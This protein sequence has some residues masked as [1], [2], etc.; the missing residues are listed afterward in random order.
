MADDKTLK[1]IN[2]IYDYVLYYECAQKDW[3][4][5]KKK[6]TI[7]GDGG[8]MKYIKWDVT[9]TTVKGDSG[10]ATKFGITH[11]TWSNYVKSHPN[12]GY[13]KDVNSMNKQGWLDVVEWFWN[14]LSYAGYAANYACAIVLFQMRWGGYSDASAKKCLSALK[15]NADKKDYNYITNG[16]SLKKIADATHAFSD[17]MKAFTILRKSLL[18]YYYNISTPNKTNKKFRVG[19]FNRVAIPFSAYGLYVDVGL[20]GGRTLKLKYESTIDDWENALSQHFKNGAKGLRKIL[21]W[22]IDPETAE[23]LIAD[24]GSYDM[25]TTEGSSS[26]GSSSGSYKGCGGVYNLGDYS[27]LPD[28]EITHQQVQSREEVLNTLLGGSYTPDD[29]KKCNELITVDKKKSIKV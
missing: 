18:T 16:A 13:N 19:W 27:N 4:D 11:G 22:G 20:N 6:G 28:M 24:S 26:S 10:G 8:L 1:V 17:P 25:S 9:S 3:L 2:S 14:N 23:K 21:D 7:T 5:Y 15:Q 12:K 29:V